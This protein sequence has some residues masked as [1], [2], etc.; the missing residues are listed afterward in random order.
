MVLE[1][2]FWEEKVVDALSNLWDG[3]GEN[4]NR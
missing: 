3:K 2:I 1:A 4:T